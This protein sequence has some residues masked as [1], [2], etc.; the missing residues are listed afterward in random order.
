MDRHRDRRHLGACGS[1][2]AEL[3]MAWIK[4]GK[5]EMEKREWV[6]EVDWP[7]LISGLHVCLCEKDR[8]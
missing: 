1:S 5:A 6:L 3:E 4:V 8:N 7:G 2:P